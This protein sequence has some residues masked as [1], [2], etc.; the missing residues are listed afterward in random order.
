[1]HRMDRRRIVRLFRA[2]CAF[3]WGHGVMHW[4]AWTL[5]FRGANLT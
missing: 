5:V 2:D 3:G 1:V 4:W